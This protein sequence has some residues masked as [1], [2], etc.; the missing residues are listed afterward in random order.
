MGLVT[1][2]L[3]G[4]AAPGVWGCLDAVADGEGIEALPPRLDAGPVGGTLRAAG[5]RG[6]DLTG[7]DAV[8]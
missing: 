3:C 4:T 5:P 2:D 8:S 6:G 1:S 7:V